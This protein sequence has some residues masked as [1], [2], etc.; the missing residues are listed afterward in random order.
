MHKVEYKKADMPSEIYWLVI[1][2]GYLIETKAADILIPH[3]SKGYFTIVQAAILT[4]VGITEGS[5]FWKVVKR[6]KRVLSPVYSIREFRVIKTS[7]EMITKFGRS[8]R[9]R[10]QIMQIDNLKF[11]IVYWKPSKKDLQVTDGYHYISPSVAEYFEI[12]GERF[13]ITFL[14]QFGAVKGDCEV[15]AMEDGI[16]L[17]ILDTKPEIY[18]HPNKKIVWLG[19]GTPVREHH[20]F[21]DIQ[22]WINM[23]GHNRV[24]IAHLYGLALTALKDIEST[25]PAPNASKEEIAKFVAMYANE[26]IIKS[27]LDFVPRLSELFSDIGINKNLDVNTFPF[28]VANMGKIVMDRVHH[29]LGAPGKG[30]K[31][32]VDGIGFHHAPEPT[33]VHHGYSAIERY[34][35]AHKITMP[36]VVLPGI[37]K[38]MI[39]LLWRSPNSIGEIIKVILI[40]SHFIDEYEAMSPHHSCGYVSDVDGPLINSILGTADFDDALQ[41]TWDKV[42][43]ENY[44]D[45]EMIVID[46]DILVDDQE[47]IVVSNFDE[48]RTTA[49]KV[50]KEATDEYGNPAF[51]PVGKYINN[52]MLATLITYCDGLYKTI[53]SELDKIGYGKRLLDVIK[54]MAPSDIVD[55]VNNGVKLHKLDRICK[56]FGKTKT[57]PLMLCWKR[58][59]K[60]GWTGHLYECFQAF[61][62][63]RDPRPRVTPYEDDLSH[64][65][66]KLFRVGIR[67][68][69]RLRLLEYRVRA[70]NA[71][72]ILP[73]AVRSPG[74]NPF[75]YKE[76]IDACLLIEYGITDAETIHQASFNK[77]RGGENCVTMVKDRNLFFTKVNSPITDGMKELSA[78]NI[79]NWKKK[80]PERINKLEKIRRFLFPNLIVLGTALRKVDPSVTLMGTLLYAF[81]DAIAEENRVRPIMG[82]SMRKGRLYGKEKYPAINSSSM[83]EK[84]KPS[85]SLFEGIDNLNTILDNNVIMPYSNP[86]IDLIYETIMV[87]DHIGQAATV[88]L[89]KSDTSDSTKLW[90]EAM[91]QVSE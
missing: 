78:F 20:A 80:N 63:C 85:R 76:S 48:F 15:N 66:A 56:V 19:L 6:L 47:P 52:K 61:S 83:Y 62:S 35:K 22:T 39:A 41:C 24:V 29:I 81:C 82:V 49:E 32:P 4:Y 9:C 65:V 40:P 34:K 50:M 7:Y 30:P 8:K 72:A 57:S 67:I 36:V 14:S 42:L 55:D 60:K 25:I 58:L 38:V 26:A 54:F 90:V 43:V 28:M 5:S 13:S 71:A 18:L 21:V 11:R 86:M 53:L 68:R 27:K 31:I 33:Y 70:L 69:N 10:V 45:E 87:V 75:S 46:R 1:G 77:Y 16:D 3:L 84:A 23:F 74:A 12:E 89:I 73:L 91:T 37:E 44:N 79:A 59:S 2:L 51:N 64:V 17:L 88:K